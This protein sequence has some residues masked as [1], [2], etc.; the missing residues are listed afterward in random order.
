MNIAAGIGILLGIAPWRVARY[1]LWLALA[2]YVVVWGAILWS[3]IDM[4]I[5]IAAAL[6]LIASVFTVAF[7]GG[8]LVSGAF[9]LLKERQA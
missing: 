6:F 1:G 9:R 5:D 7:F 8:G 2:L 3:R 4:S